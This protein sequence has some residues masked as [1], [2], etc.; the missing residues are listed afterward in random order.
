MMTIG[1]VLAHKDNRQPKR[2]W[3]GEVPRLDNMGVPIKDEFIDGKSWLG[4]WGL[5][6]PESW[7][8]VGVGR[9]GT[10]LGQRYRKQADGKWLKVEG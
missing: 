4:P 1:D 7:S 2:Y 10:G 3:R 6:V 8:K 5:F 9:L